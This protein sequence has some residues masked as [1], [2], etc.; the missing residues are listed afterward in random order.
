VSS[1]TRGNY[2]SS[3]I[4]ITSFSHALWLCAGFSAAGAL[5]GLAYSSRNAI[6][7]QHERTLSEQP[8]AS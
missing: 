6:S 5:V 7:A 2:T 3:S 1:P 8:S 4:F